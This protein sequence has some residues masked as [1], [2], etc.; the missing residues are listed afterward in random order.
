MRQC[1]MD[2]KDNKFNGL[3]S[4]GARRPVRLSSDLVKKH[5]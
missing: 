3:S 1:E 4:G 5:Y 2:N